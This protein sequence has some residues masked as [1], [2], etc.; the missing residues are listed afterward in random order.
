MCV[1][2]R[3]DVAHREVSECEAGECGAGDHDGHARCEPGDADAIAFDLLW[4]DRRRSDASMLWWFGFRTPPRPFR[5]DGVAGPACVPL[6][7]PRRR[8]S[9]RSNGS[10]YRAAP[11]AKQ[12][13]SFCCRAGRVVE[14]SR[15]SYA[16]SSFGRP[17]RRFAICNR[18]HVHVVRGPTPCGS[19]SRPRRFGPISGPIRQLPRACKPK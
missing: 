10:A 17:L 15:R 12:L 9:T 1:R 5:G 8:D 4:P 19:R 3:R 7:R 13:D 18:E 6:W 2:P 14:K 16:R 11:I